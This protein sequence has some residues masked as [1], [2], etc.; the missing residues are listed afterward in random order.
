MKTNLQLC[1]NLKT[2]LQNDHLPAWGS[3]YE[4]TLTQVDEDNVQFIE[5]PL[6]LPTVHRNPHIYDGK[7]ITLTLRP[8]GTVQPHFRTL[9]HEATGFD[10]DSYT[11]DVFDELNRALHQCLVMKA[12]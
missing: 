1:I 7:N 4:G 12:K 9:R 6:R 3:N 11:L 5:R 8:D 10:I 2:F